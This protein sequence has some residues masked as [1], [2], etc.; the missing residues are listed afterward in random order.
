MK[1][2]IVIINPTSGKNKKLKQLAQIGKTLNEYGYSCDILLTQYKGHATEIIKT[3]DYA[4]LV[5]SVGGDGTFNEVMTGN[6]KR[7]ERILLAHI[8][9]GTANDIGAMYGYKKDIIENLKL[10]LNGE[11]KDIDICTINGTPFTYCAA[12][13]KLT[14]ISYETP[15]PMKKKYGYLAYLIYGLKEIQGKTKLYDIK[16]KIDDKEYTNKVSFILISNANRIA[17]IN[18]FYDNV[19]LDDNRFEVLF[20]NLVTKREIIKA[21]YHLTKS[22]ITK[23]PGFSFHKVSN[24]NIE[25]SKLPSRG[26]SIDG[27]EYNKNDLVYQINIVRNVKLLIPQKNIDKLFLS[28]E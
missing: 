13:G 25:F 22:D 6:F 27:E 24:L 21:I 16:Y 5:I 3:I 2:C 9:L 17:G 10:L 23:V 1:K 20:C 15:K 19:L 14:N 8:P 12:F 4:D 26:W 7:K 18:N 28:K 11:I